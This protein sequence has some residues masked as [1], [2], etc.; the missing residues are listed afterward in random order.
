MVPCH[1]QHSQWGSAWNKVVP[2]RCNI[3]L[4]PISMLLCRFFDMLHAFG[5][6][7]LGRRFSDFSEKSGNRYR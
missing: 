5:T 2:Q 6:E 3:P 1:N 4:Q 7:A